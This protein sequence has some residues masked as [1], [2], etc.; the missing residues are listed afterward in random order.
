M[1]PNAIPNRK[2]PQHGV[3]GAYYGGEWVDLEDCA[4]TFLP[5]SDAPTSDVTYRSKCDACPR[6]ADCEGNRGTHQVRS[7]SKL[8]SSKDGNGKEYDVLII[9]AGCVG[10]LC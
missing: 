10:T 1:A 6:K 9:G 8:D 7:R 2:L 3:N 5:S 4:N